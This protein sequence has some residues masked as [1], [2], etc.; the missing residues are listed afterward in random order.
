MNEKP[1]LDRRD[2]LKQ[3]AGAVGAGIGTALVWLAGLARGPR[4]GL[5]ALTVSVFGGTL[6]RRSGVPRCSASRE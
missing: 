5:R 3:A 2:F 1:G 6:Y 4:T